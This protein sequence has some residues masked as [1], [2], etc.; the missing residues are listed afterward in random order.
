[1]RNIY[2]SAPSRLICGFRLWFFYAGFLSLASLLFPP[3]FLPLFFF[4][5][6]YKTRANRSLVLSCLVNL[7]TWIYNFKQEIKSNQHWALWNKGHQRFAQHLY[8]HLAFPLYQCVKVSPIGLYSKS[9]VFK[10]MGDTFTHWYR[11]MAICPLF[12]KAQCWSDLISCF[13]IIHPSDKVI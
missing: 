6:K 4:K 11:G 1:M 13:E 7:I 12:Y 2:S 10:S 3:R 8:N 5:W 9:H